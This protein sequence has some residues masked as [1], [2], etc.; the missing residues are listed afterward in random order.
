MNSTTSCGAIA[1]LKGCPGMSQTS[2]KRSMRTG[3]SGT[4][5]AFCTTGQLEASVDR[6]PDAGCTI[7]GGGSHSGASFDAIHGTMLASCAQ[8]AG[9]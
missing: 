2:V 3:S 5:V 6:R 8:P 7:E 1:A 4:G 9:G